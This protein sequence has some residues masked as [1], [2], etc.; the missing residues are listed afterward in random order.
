MPSDQQTDPTL[1]STFT[2]HQLGSLRQ[3]DAPPLFL[4]FSKLDRTATCLWIV[5]TDTIRL[6]ERGKHQPTAG[7]SASQKCL[8]AFTK[9]PKIILNSW[10]GEMAPFEKDLLQNLKF[11][12]QH[13]C[14]K[15]GTVVLRS[16][17]RGG[18]VVT[19][20]SWG[21]TACLIDKHQ[22]SS[23]DPVSKLKVMAPEG[24]HLR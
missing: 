6:S 8:H 14:K 4:H 10:A 21:L 13:L 3:V 7:S 24:P 5:E 11:I 19:A 23:T 17:S 16:S 18:K 12:L 1:S 20:K 9:Y 22:V 15:W 2:I